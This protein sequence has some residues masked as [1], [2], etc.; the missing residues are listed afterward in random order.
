[1]AAGEG[2]ALRKVITR[3]ANVTPYGASDA[4]GDMS[5]SAIIEFR[6]LLTPGVPSLLMSAQLE[7]HVATLP[8]GC[9]F[10]VELYAASPT[11]IIDNNLWDL[12]GADRALHI[13][14]INIGAPADRG[15][16][17]KAELDLINKVLR[18]GAG[19]AANAPLARSLFA[20]IV[21]PAGFTPA[22]NSE[23]LALTLATAPL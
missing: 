22:A 13:G 14:S 16:T 23:T 6:G 4:V 2:R 12:A 19:G 15:S 21:T 20:I 1:M 9:T 8:V 3:P 18:P 10:T 5:G 11:A 17:L 7:Y